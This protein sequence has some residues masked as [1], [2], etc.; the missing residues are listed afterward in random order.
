MGFFCGTMLAM[1]LE[2]ASEDPAY[3]DMASKFFEH[4]V[5]IADAINT[6]GGQGLWDE[7][8]GFYYDQIHVAGEQQAIRLRSMVGAIPVFACHNLEQ[9]KI[10]RLPGFRKR[11]EWFLEN[12]SD[13]AKHISYMEGR[14]AGHVH[15]LLAIP[16]RER[17]ERLLRYL[18]DEREFLSPYGL[19]SVSKVYEAHPYMLRLRGYDLELR[20]DP[21]ESRTGLFGGNSNWRGPVWFPLNYLMIEAL[22]CY[23]HFYGDSFTVEMPTGSGRRMTLRQVA[24]ELSGRLSSLFLPDGSGHRPCHGSDERYARDP[25]WK[26]LILFY[27]YFQGDDG[28]GLGASHQT[29]WTA[30][31][32]RCVGDVARERAH[33]EDS[34]PSPAARP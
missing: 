15:R 6:L 4:F 31:V 30:L 8:D 27:E 1:A 29:G 10:D 32:A 17:L 13:L 12:R 22:E 2:L 14:E 23:H 20:Y 21:A 3:E 9:K 11:M 24:L 26:D 7:E 16:T 18:L 28:R 34:S 33:R 5:A 19:R 25:A